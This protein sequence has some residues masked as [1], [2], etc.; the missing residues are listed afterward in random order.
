MLTFHKYLFNYSFL[1]T[2][3]HLVIILRQY[4]YPKVI[5][6][7]GIRQLIIFTQFTSQLIHGKQTLLPFFFRHILQLFRR[8]DDFIPLALDG[9]FIKSCKR[10]F[11]KAMGGDFQ[12]SISSVSLFRYRHAQP[13]SPRSKL[14]AI[15]DS[16][17][18]FKTA[19]IMV[20]LL[21]GVIV[22]Y[23]ANLK[24]HSRICRR[25]LQQYLMGLSVPVDIFLLIGIALQ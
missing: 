23:P 2:P 7:S 18:R 3:R 12:L 16:L 20:T 21:G 13:F 11:K 1:T 9:R 10:H 14:N 6:Q 4:A 15:S 17:V 19:H 5:E 24:L 22:R 8:L 25:Q